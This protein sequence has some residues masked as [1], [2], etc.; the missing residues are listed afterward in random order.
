MMTE[1][2]IYYILHN[3]NNLIKRKSYRINAYV[4]SHAFDPRP[5]YFYEKI[6]LE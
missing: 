1:W 6:V 5:V 3:A 4:I 2:I